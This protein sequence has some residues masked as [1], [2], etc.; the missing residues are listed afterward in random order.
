MANVSRYK[1]RNEEARVVFF[2]EKLPGVLKA[3]FAIVP[4][5]KQ[6]ASLR[7]FSPF[8]AALEKQIEKLRYDVNYY[9]VQSTKASGLDAAYETLQKN[10][11]DPEA[12]KAFQEELAGKFI[13]ES[14]HHSSYIQ[15]SLVDL[16]KTCSEMVDLL[17]QEQDED[18]RTNGAA[19]EHLFIRLKNFVP[20]LN[21]SLQ[22]G[23]IY[24]GF[25]K[26]R[27]F[28]H[29]DICVVLRYFY[30]LVWYASPRSTNPVA[31]I[32]TETL[33]VLREARNVSSN[34]QHTVLRREIRD[35]D[36]LFWA[37]RESDVASMIFG[38]WCILCG[39][40]PVNY[41]DVDSHAF[42]FYSCCFHCPHVVLD[43]YHF[44]RCHCGWW[45]GRDYKCSSMGKYWVYLWCASGRLS[46]Y[47]QDGHI[48]FPMADSR[49]QGKGRQDY[50]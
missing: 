50:G 38:E 16:Y 32:Q 25:L 18:R 47:T 49:W 40:F 23:H 22:R 15:E 7:Q 14:Y 19:T 21:N 33:G 44:A 6:D 41:Q 27:R 11:N 17:E 3:V 37:T 31:P 5:D 2:D 8:E 45:L 35:L 36:H 13:A 10:T 9:N 39:V 20:R 28:G 12:I 24:W 29:W 48:V 1:I 43:L 34:F 46:L 4:R 30:S 26:H 42:T